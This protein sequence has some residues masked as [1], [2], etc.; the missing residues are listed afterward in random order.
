MSENPVLL[1]EARLFATAALVC[2]RLL[3]FEHVWQYRLIPDTL[4]W[5]H[6]LQRRA[7]WMA[8]GGSHACT[9]LSSS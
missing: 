3:L 9:P 4:T 7:D 1:T 6:S 5:R 8:A 2:D